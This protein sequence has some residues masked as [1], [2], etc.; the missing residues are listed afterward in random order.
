MCAITIAACYC[1]L[2]ETP[3]LTN[4]AS[5]S[6]SVTLYDDVTN[7]ALQPQAVCNPFFQCDCV[8]RAELQLD[9]LTLHQTLML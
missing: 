4:T 9:M 7:T 2:S 8:P 3:I 5:P 6:V 1:T